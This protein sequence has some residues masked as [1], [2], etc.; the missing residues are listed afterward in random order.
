MRFRE[1][2]C[3]GSRSP[4]H[5][6]KIRAMLRD[7][8]SQVQPTC[9]SRSSFLS[10]KPRIVSLRQMLMKHAFGHSVVHIYQGLASERYRLNNRWHYAK[11]NTVIR[12]ATKCELRQ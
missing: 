11:D 1:S 2:D 5:A 8:L 6:D 12:L 3:R 10:R 7:V 9:S 4:A